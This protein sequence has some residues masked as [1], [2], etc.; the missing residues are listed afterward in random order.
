[1][2]A[3]AGQLFGRTESSAA[4]FEIMGASVS[5]L[6][7]KRCKRSVVMIKHLRAFRG[8]Q[9]ISYRSALPASNQN[10]RA[11]ELDS[12]INRRRLRYISALDNA[13]ARDYTTGVNGESLADGSILD[14][15]ARSESEELGLHARHGLRLRRR[16]DAVQPRD[17]VPE[18]VLG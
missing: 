15:C 12:Q 13:I 17:S 2:C 10:L 9:R 8:R 3:L 11:G 1:M 5:D 7:P 14:R 4:A 16:F 6:A 18:V